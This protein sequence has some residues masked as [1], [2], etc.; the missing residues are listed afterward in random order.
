MVAQVL[1][2]RGLQYYPATSSGESGNAT[3]RSRLTRVGATN[4]QLTR[5]T[6]PRDI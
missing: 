4:A 3:Q 1:L 2:A 5:S 6:E